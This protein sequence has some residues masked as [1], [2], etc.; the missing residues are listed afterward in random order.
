MAS[1]SW[2]WLIAAVLRKSA[3]PL[4]T[5]ASRTVHPSATKAL[6]NGTSLSIPTSTTLTKAPKKRNKR[7]GQAPIGLCEGNVRCIG[8][9]TFLFI[10]RTEYIHADPHTC[11]ASKHGGSTHSGS[12]RQEDGLRHRLRKGRERRFCRLD[13]C[14]QK[15]A[16]HAPSMIQQDPNRGPGGGGS[17]M[18]LVPWSAANTMSDAGAATGSSVR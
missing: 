2:S 11:R 16:H 14:K 1:A 7:I 3:V 6:P 13:T 18:A 15:V 17:A 12:D 9:A 8:K 10:P 5:L 4:A